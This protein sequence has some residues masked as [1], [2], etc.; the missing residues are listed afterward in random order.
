MML[1][2]TTDTE[3]TGTFCRKCF[4]ILVPSFS[5]VCAFGGGVVDLSPRSPP[6]RA[7]PQMVRGRPSRVVQLRF[8]LS[9]L[10]GWLLL[11]GRF[12]LGEFL[13]RFLCIVSVS[14]ARGASALDS[15]GPVLRSCRDHAAH[16]ILTARHNCSG[17]ARMSAEI[18]MFQSRK[19]PTAETSNPRGRRNPRDTRDGNDAGG[20]TWVNPSEF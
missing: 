14:V 18:P 17:H 10:I 6:A 2:T 19:R 20:L 4:Q 1:L 9:L 15:Q 13:S 11:V 12:S 8:G 5:F 7:H 16:G 3:Q